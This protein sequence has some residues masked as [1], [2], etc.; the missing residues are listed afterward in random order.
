MQKY[1][2]T[3][4]RLIFVGKGLGGDSYMTMYKTDWA[5]AGSHRLK[6]KA[7]PPRETEAEAQADL[8]AYAKAKG[9]ESV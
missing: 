1:C 2:D 4:G 8:D 3:K 9:L 5:A 6:A 7:L